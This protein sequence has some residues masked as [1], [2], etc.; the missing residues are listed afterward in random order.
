MLKSTSPK[1]V[2]WGTPL[3]TGFHLNVEPLIT[4]LSAFQPIPYPPG[5][6]S[7]KYTSLQFGDKDVVGDLVKGLALND[8]GGLQNQLSAESVFDIIFFIY[9]S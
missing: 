1:T 6:S 2:P 5:S 9:T 4:T 8:T 3:V 7:V